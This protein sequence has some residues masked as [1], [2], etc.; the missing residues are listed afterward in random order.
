MKIYGLTGGIACGKSA[1]TKRLRKAGVSVVDAD[2]VARAVVLPGSW[3]LSRVVAVFGKEVLHADG[4]LN[5]EKLGKMIFEDSDLR[6]Q[7]NQALGIPIGLEI[8]KRIFLCWLAGDSLVFLDAPTLY[9]TKVFVGICSKVVVVSAPEKIQ[10]ERLMK[11]DACSAPEGEAKISSQMSIEKKIARCHIHVDNRG[12]FK[13]LN[14]RVDALIETA[15][16]DS[17]SVLSRA[18]NVHF[19]VLSLWALAAYISGSGASA[20]A[21]ATAIAGAVGIASSKMLRSRL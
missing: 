20:S 12:T 4:T 18:T 17:E 1:V 15:R 19:V 7:I 10:L 13:E 11:R 14:A 16:K 8:V 5:R 2:V 3:G 9:E 6:K 21:L